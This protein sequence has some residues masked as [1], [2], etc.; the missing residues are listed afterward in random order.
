MIE[1]KL[2][3]LTT[4]VNTTA[5][6]VETAI[7]KSNTALDGVQ[8]IG[9]HFNFT[10]S[11]WVEIFATINDVPGRFKT[12]ITDQRLSFLDNSV[13]VAYMSN[14][15]LYIT[16]AQILNSLQLGTIEQSKTAKGGL[17]YQWKG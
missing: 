17:I 15:Q 3:T 2:T 11:G 14:Q 8:T 9:K 7:T 1:N 6:G 12:R 10:D 4:I 5:Q 16:Q 13:E